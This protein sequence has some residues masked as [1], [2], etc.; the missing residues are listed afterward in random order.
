MGTLRSGITS[1]ASFQNSAS[2]G[3]ASGSEL[4]AAI[5]SS[6]LSR[7]TRLQ[8]VFPLLLPRLGEYLTIFLSFTSTSSPRRN[9]TPIATAPSIDDEKFNTIGYTNSGDALFAVAPIYFFE[10][11]ALENQ[12]RLH[13]INMMLRDVL[14]VLGFVP[15][16]PFKH[17]LK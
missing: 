5:I 7:A 4:A 13:E 12:H 14:K 1:R 17:C 16:I 6:S 15:F 3:S 10:N 9:N 8:S 2:V 11:R